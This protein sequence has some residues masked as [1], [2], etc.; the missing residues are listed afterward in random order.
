[1]DATL[2]AA[3][4][5]QQSRVPRERLPQVAQISSKV[6]EYLTELEKEN[7]VSK[8]EMVSTTDPDAVLASKAPGTALMAYYDNYV[9]DTSSRVI[10]GVEASPALFHQQTVAARK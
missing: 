2:I 4:A 9:I 1:M 8:A 5:S 3:D 6:K 10:L 7:P